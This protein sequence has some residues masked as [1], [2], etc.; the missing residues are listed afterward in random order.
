MTAKETEITKQLS[1]L[2]GSGGVTIDRVVTHSQ[3]LELF[4]SWPEPGKGHRTC[5][6]C[7][8]I[9][10]NKKDGGAMQTIRH[11]PIGS[12]GTMVTFHK[13]RYVCLDCGKTFFAHP[14]FVAPGLSISRHLFVLIYEKLTSTAHNR[15]EIAIETCTSPDI[16]DSVMERC[17][18]DHPKFLPETLGV[19]E[20]KGESGTWDPARSRFLV[21]EYH[22]VIT[23][24]S[25]SGGRVLDILISPKASA[26]KKYFMGF[27]GLEREHVKFFCTDMRPG[28]SSVAKACFPH[29]RVCIDPFHVVRL[30]TEALVSIKVAEQNRLLGV[31]NAA[32]EEERGQALAD[33]RLVKNCARM[34]TTSPYNGKRPWN[35]ERNQKEK[36]ERMERVFSLA[37]DLKQPYE[38]LHAFYDITHREEFPLQRAALTDWLKEYLTCETPELRTAAATIRKYRQGIENAWKFHKSNSPTEGINKRIKDLK[39]AEFGARSFG[40]FRQRILLAFG[41]ESFVPPLYT[42]REDRATSPS[43]KSGSR[44]GGK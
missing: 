37:P 1:G 19:D 13:P 36:A 16:V 20:F 44:K 9:H 17:C 23:D 28:F 41:Y 25:G 27:T 6:E 33:Y 3:S 26:L 42:I 39:R 5:P 30:L 14:D 40:N 18:T 43:L 4:V 35:Q 24:A 32:P 21:E 22:C 7:G 29:A 11:T 15:R 10:C 2:T 8:S 12:T 34:L 31:A 38:A